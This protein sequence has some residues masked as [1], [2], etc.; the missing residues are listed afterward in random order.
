MEYVQVNGKD[1]DSQCYVGAIAM[2]KKRNA[3]SVVN[4]IASVSNDSSRNYGG[5]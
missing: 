2:K 5:T 3:R 4:R 1:W